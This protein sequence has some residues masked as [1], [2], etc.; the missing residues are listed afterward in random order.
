MSISAAAKAPTLR[1]IPMSFLRE[2]DRF[3]AIALALPQRIVVTGKADM[4]GYSVSEVRGVRAGHNPNA[5][6]YINVQFDEPNTPYRHPHNWCHPNDTIYGEDWTIW[7][8]DSIYQRYQEDLTY[9]I[10]LQAQRDEHTRAQSAR[11]E[12]NRKKDEIVKSI[13]KAQR[14]LAELQKKLDEWEKEV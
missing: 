6:T 10:R 1:V 3:V 11:H 9:N 14:N 8:A 12:A 13:A 7:V 5:R 4:D 2:G